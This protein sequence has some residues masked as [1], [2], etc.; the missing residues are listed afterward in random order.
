[1][2]F[3]SNFRRMAQQFSQQI[4]VLLKQL[5]VLQQQ[6]NAF[7][8]KIRAAVEEPYHCAD[9]LAD[10]EEILKSYYTLREAL[11]K[12]G[13]MNIPITLA[14]PADPSQSAPIS[15]PPTTESLEQMTKRLQEQIQTSHGNIERIRKSAAFVQSRLVDKI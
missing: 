13:L 7:F 14:P 5:E 1:L 4:D 6:V 11:E 15:E 12:S 2:C 8:E 10:K 3:V 9:A